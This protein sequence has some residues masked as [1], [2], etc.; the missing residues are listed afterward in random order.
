[1]N[2]S[3]SFSSNDDEP[4][5]E[6]WVN[7][8]VEIFGDDKQHPCCVAMLDQDRQCKE[9]GPQEPEEHSC[10]PVNVSHIGHQRGVAE[11]FVPVPAGLVKGEMI[12]TIFPSDKNFLV[13]CSN[14]YPLNN[15]DLWDVLKEHF[16]TR[17]ESGHIPKSVRTEVAE[18]LLALDRKAQ[19]ESG[20]P[21]SRFRIWKVQPPKARLNE[22][23]WPSLMYKDIT[24]NVGMLKKYLEWPLRKAREDALIAFFESLFNDE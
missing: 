13:G 18:V 24:S 22:R 14:F 5:E 8:L 9:R 20:N 1:M 19:R 4:K 21:S 11:A 15:T 17:I 2:P 6:G 12:K 16:M 7:D 10:T 23:N 3:N